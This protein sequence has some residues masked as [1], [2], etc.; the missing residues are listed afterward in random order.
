MKKYS[1]AALV[2]A[3]VCLAIFLITATAPAASAT[4]SA[5]EEIHLD[6]RTEKYID[7]ATTQD[8]GGNGNPIGY[9]AGYGCGNSSLNDIVYF[10]DVDFGST[11]AMAITLLFGFDNK[12]GETTDLNF[13]IDGYDPKNLVGQ[14]QVGDTGGWSIIDAKE[15]TFPVIIPA[16]VHS[17]YI[18]FTTA[19]SGSFSYIRF[20]TVYDPGDAQVPAEYSGPPLEDSAAVNIFADELLNCF[21][22]KHQM[23]CAVEEGNLKMT[24]IED[25]DDPYV[26]FEIDDYYSA[27]KSTP[28]SADDY[29][30]VVIRLKADETITGTDFELF[31]LCGAVE[32]A[33]EAAYQRVS[34]VAGGKWECIM[35]SFQNDT[36]WAG[37][38][39]S[40]RL[41]WNTGSKTGESMEI[42]EIRFVK[43]LAEAWTFIA[44]TSGEDE[45]TAADV[46]DETSGGQ[47]TE[48]QQVTEPLQ[49]EATEPGTAAE[50]TDAVTG[51]GDN[52][53]GCSSAAAFGTFVAV[54]AAAAV[55]RR[56]R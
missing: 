14:A 26:F 15:V 51:S 48:S 1:R 33:E 37:T 56:R 40:L 52:E 25:T 42:S 53:K 6:G 13:Y 36:R 31:G 8:L 32:R 30:L 22:D 44:A 17:V 54:C 3:A 27:V 55:I 23:N 47:E 18:Q 9:V 35:F 11:G 12:N 43:T 46:G 5:F 41:D 10:E 49:T 19:N 34:Y 39:N 24:A 45:E 29:K 16:G 2:L 50:Q 20:G 38:I 7:D 28:V 21:R 4:L